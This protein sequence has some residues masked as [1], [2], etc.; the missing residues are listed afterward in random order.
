[1]PGHEITT[2]PAGAHIRIEIDGEVVA[3]SD[4]AIALEETGLPT[5]YYLPRSDVSA[6]LLD[7]DTHTHCPF[8]G[9]ASYHSIGEHRDVVWYYPE[10]RDA[11]DAIRDHVAFW[12][13]DIFAD[14]E[15][16]A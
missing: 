14:G 9:D 11:V 10:P 8:K 12:N 1:M 16:Q 6:E 13:V 5:R 3:E 4:D 7:S 2:A 15:R